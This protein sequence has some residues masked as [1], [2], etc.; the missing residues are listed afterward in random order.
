[1][2]KTNDNLLQCM[3][4]VLW[5]TMLMLVYTLKISWSFCNLWLFSTFYNKDT[6]IDYESMQQYFFLSKCQTI[7]KTIGTIQMLGSCTRL[8]SQTHR[9][10]FKNQGSFLF[11]LMKLP[12]WI[13]NFSWAFMCT[14]L[15]AKNVTL[16]YWPW[17]N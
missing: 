13:A 15:M 2:L 1:M 6:L 17:N 7:P 9:W 5:L 11:L 3:Q 16:F 14:L 8:C 10:L 4:E 12:L